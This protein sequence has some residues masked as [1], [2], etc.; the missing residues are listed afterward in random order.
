MHHFDNYVTNT[1]CHRISP[2]ITIGPRVTNLYDHL[3]GGGSCTGDL[4]TNR[5]RWDMY[6]LT[7]WGN[8]TSPAIIGRQQ[9]FL[10]LFGT[11]LPQSLI[12]LS[13]AQAS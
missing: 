1:L 8:A 6:A 5:Q 4:Y 2:S 13:V 11:T 10:I 3:R 9:G 7:A 12:R